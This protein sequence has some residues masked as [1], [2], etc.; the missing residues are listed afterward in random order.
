M[1]CLPLIIL[2]ISL[3]VPAATVLA[4]DT[5][6]IA[7]IVPRNHSAR[8]NVDELSLIFSRKKLYWS[9]GKKIHP[10]N[11]SSDHPLRR[12]FSRVVLKSLPEEQTEYWNGLY[13]HG[14]SPPHVVS[15]QEAMLRFVSETTGSIGYVN[16]C[17]VNEQVR[18]LL[19]INDQG[20]I[21]AIEPQLNCDR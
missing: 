12:Q 1:R 14:T 19:W 17:M 8:L 20:G 3:M 18:V 9:N 15:S 16:A 7:V 10:V 2:A 4:A 11:L 6:A 5:Q 21:S 13:Y